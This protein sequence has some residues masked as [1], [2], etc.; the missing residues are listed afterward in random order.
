MKLKH[1]ALAV[2]VVCLFLLPA[3]LMAA[4]NYYR[5]EQ[6]DGVWWLVSP[7]GQLMIS[8]GVDNVSHLGDAVRG[9]AVHPYFDNISKLYPTE[10]AWA[11]TEISRLRSWGVNNLGAQIAKQFPSIG[12]LVRI[13]E[14]QFGIQCLAH[15]CQMPGDAG[16]QSPLAS[17]LR[18]EPEPG[19]IVAARPIER[20]RISEIHIAERKRPVFRRARSLR[21]D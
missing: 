4:G 17:S 12:K 10:N 5:V 11:N 18:R 1:L 13:D 6:R 19:H 14:D 2:G 3:R 20:I 16:W 8:A 21:L 9:T 15:S 7:S